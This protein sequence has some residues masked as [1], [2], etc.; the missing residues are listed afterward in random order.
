M[1]NTSI[2]DMGFKL[3]IADPDVYIRAF[4][5]PNGFKYYEYILVYG[6]DV[7][8]I[9]RAPKEHLKV[10]QATYELNPASVGPPTRYLLGGLQMSRK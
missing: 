4:A 10:I 2:R 7:L 8:I 1:F 6:N 3:S 9:S 5:K